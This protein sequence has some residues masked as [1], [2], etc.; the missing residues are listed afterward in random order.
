MGDGKSSREI[1]WRPS[2]KNRV[3]KKKVPYLYW[4]LLHFCWRYKYYLLIQ[5]KKRIWRNLPNLLHL[6]HPYPG[7][8]IQLCCPQL[9]LNWVPQIINSFSDVNRGSLKKESAYFNPC[10]RAV[11]TRYRR[12]GS[13]NNRNVLS[14]SSGC[15][16]S[17]VKVFGR[18]ASSE[19]PLLFPPFVPL[20]VPNFRFLLGHQ[21]FC[22][23]GL[24]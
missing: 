7:S 15:W 8:T 24:S 4:G 14:P 6:C 17:E 11:G 2:K 1:D 18:L 9:F 23:Y 3:K 21:S 20:F 5:G 22:I 16:Q 12:P 19:V 13:L 10:T